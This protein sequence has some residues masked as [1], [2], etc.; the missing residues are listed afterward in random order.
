[1]LHDVYRKLENVKKCPSVF[2]VLCAYWNS[3]PVVAEQVSKFQTIQF[4]KAFQMKLLQRA[5]AFQS[6]C[7]TFYE[8]S[9]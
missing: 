5:G 6:S 7:L 2:S 3:C 9:L 1:M 8:F 4:K